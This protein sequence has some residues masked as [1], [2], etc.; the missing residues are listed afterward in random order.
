MEPSSRYKSIP[1]NFQIPRTRETRK[2]KNPFKTG[3]LASLPKFPQHNKLLTKTA[4]IPK[5][6]H[7]HLRSKTRIRQEINNSKISKRDRLSRRARNSNRSRSARTRQT[8]KHR[9][10]S[11]RRRHHNSKPY[12][13]RSQI[14]GLSQSASQYNQLLRSSYYSD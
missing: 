11:K 12:I 1:R 9:Q 14:A 6:I 5:P 10:H 8:N 2:A 13:R 3:Q 7:I 4:L